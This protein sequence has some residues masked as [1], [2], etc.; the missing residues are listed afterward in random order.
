MVF[1]VQNDQTPSDAE[2]NE[3]LDILRSRRA[4]LARVKVL[5]RTAGGAP[6]AGQ[7]KDLEATL[8]GVRFRVAVVSDSVKVRFI[9]S[10]IALFHRDHRSFGV[11]Q[12][13]EAYDHLQLTPQERVL[14]ASTVRELL[15][16]LE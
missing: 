14:A 12:T 9:A 3:F 16:L 10:V 11:T 4:D 7:R 6:D 5:V 15:H 8:N 13:T 1:V 2:W